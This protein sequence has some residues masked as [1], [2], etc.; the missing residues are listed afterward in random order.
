[1]SI[2]A[3]YI[4]DLT[5]NTDQTSYN[6]N[7]IDSELLP[8]KENHGYKN[9]NSL[10]KA[11]RSVEETFKDNCNTNEPNNRFL[12][13][14]SNRKF[15]ITTVPTNKPL[16]NK[17]KSHFFIISKISNNNVALNT[18]QN[19]CNQKNIHIYIDLTQKEMN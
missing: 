15:S 9:S 2:S 1:M 12:I 18:E 13:S 16:L 11:D 5:T 14:K 17:H 8:K 7:I 3:D 4:F 6:Y 10:V 19:H